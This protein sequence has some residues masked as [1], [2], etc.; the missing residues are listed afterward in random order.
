M[1]FPGVTNFPT[2][3]IRGAGRATLSGNLAP[4]FHMKHRLE[5]ARLIDR[6][7]RP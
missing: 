6:R 3:L 4:S 5:D 2:G 7:L 1:G